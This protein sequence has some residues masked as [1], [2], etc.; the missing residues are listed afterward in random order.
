MV[1]AFYK[2]GERDLIQYTVAYLGLVKPCFLTSKL[3]FLLKYIQGFLTLFMLMNNP[4]A[5]K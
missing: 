3:G 2:D 1:D 5:E 4:Y